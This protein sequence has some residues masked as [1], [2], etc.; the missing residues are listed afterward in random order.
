MFLVLLLLEPFLGSEPLRRRSD[1]DRV[2]GRL[3]LFASRFIVRG[4]LLSGLAPGPLAATVAGHAEEEEQH[5]SEDVGEDDQCIYC[6]VFFIERRQ[7]LSS[8]SLNIH[9]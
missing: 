4:R 9:V 2:R 8:P 6:V 5:W 1:Q 3:S 7:L